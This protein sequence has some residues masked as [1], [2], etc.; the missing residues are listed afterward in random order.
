MAE[1]VSDAPVNGRGEVV[2]QHQANPLSRQR[3]RRQYLLCG[4]QVLRPSVPMTEERRHTGSPSFLKSNSTLARG[5]ALLD[6]WIGIGPVLWVALLRVVSIFLLHSYLH[7]VSWEFGEIATAIHAGYGYTIALPSGGR[8]PLVYMPPAY[9]YLLVLVLKCGGGPLPWLVLELIQAG[10]GVVLVYA[11]YRTALLLAER[12]VA[13]TA[14]ILVAVYPTQVYTCNEFHS[15]NFYVVL[16]AG[17]VFYLR[18]IWRN[19]NS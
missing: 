8:A 6:R 17:A 7:P 10:L 1:I 16:G 5:G 18:D 14:A 19:P 9:P 11:I 2:V 3:C 15:I 4:A 13:I 12:R